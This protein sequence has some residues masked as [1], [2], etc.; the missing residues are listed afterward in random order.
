[1]SYAYVF[2][3]VRS[4]GRARVRLV[5][6]IQ[7]V[8][9]PVRYHLIGGT[10]A[11]GTSTLMARLFC[12]GR[13]LFL[14]RN[15]RACCRGVQVWFSCV[16]DF[17]VRFD[18]QERVS[19]PR[20]YGT[21]LQVLL[22]GC[23]R[24][25]L[26]LFLAQNCSVRHFATFRRVVRRFKDGKNRVGT[27]SNRSLSMCWSCN[28]G[29]WETVNG[30]AVRL[31]GWEFIFWDCRVECKIRGNMGSIFLDGRVWGRRFVY[32]CSFVGR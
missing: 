29:R 9:R 19:I 16:E 4:V 26:R 10:A 25:A 30:G 17:L 12:L 15:P 7:V 6:P 1:M 20:P 22:L 28:E 18:V 2:L 27:A 24:E 31:F 11:H 5:G 3:F 13:G 8:I 32:L 21:W 23:P 14:R